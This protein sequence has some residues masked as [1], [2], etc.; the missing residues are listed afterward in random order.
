[1][2]VAAGRSADAVDGGGFAL[3]S[4]QRAAR[5]LADFGGPRLCESPT[6]PS[7]DPECFGGVVHQNSR[8]FNEARAPQCAKHQT[9]LTGE[10]CSTLR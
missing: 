1:M 8:R 5:C 3:G 7:S 10:S 9:D 6:R 4:D 2:V